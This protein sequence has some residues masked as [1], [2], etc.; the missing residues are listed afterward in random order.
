[1]T[2]PAHSL[3]PASH[4]PLRKR[5]RAFTIPPWRDWALVGW[6]L[7]RLRSHPLDNND[8]FDRASRR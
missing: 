3:R 1:M 6:D 7:N 2:R 4:L 8:R 5:T